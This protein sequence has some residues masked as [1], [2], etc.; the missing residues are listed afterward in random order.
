MSDEVKTASCVWCD[1]HPYI[2][3]YIYMYTYIYISITIY[4]VKQLRKYM[5]FH[6]ISVCDTTCQVFNMVPRLI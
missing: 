5:L 4:I 2:H 6:I 1:K 3:A